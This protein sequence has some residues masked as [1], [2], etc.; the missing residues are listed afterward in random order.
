MI[1]HSLV[2]DARQRRITSGHER[3][4]PLQEYHSDEWFQR[5]CSLQSQ[6]GYVHRL[7]L[8]RMPNPET[9][10][11]RDLRQPTPRS[12]KVRST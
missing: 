7:P 8:V 10:N 11:H 3:R 9:Q 6:L 1:S 4:N 2:S 12:A 5:L